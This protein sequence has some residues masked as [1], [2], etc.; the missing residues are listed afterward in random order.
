MAYVVMAYVVM[1]YAVMALRL[2]SSRPACANELLALTV[3][4]CIAM[5]YIVMA[6]M[7][8]SKYMSMHKRAGLP[9]GRR[10]L[11][12]RL[13]HMPTRMSVHMWYWRFRKGRNYTVMAYVFM[14]CPCTRGTGGSGRAI[15]V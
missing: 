10:V 2:E 3:V 15:T 9:S 8:V 6:D 1:A 7:V 5:V 11:N 4:A 12:T 13:L 14:A